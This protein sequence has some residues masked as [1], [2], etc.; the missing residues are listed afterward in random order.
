MIRLPLPCPC[1]L[2][3]RI[4]QRRMRLCIR[5]GMV[6]RLHECVRQQDR[7]N[8]EPD[9]QHRGTAVFASTVHARLLVRHYSIGLK[10]SVWSPQKRPTAL[11]MQT[12]FLHRPRN[13]TAALLSP[14]G[15]T[16][17]SRPR[18]DWL[19]CANLPLFSSRPL[20]SSTSELLLETSC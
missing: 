15:T 16:R 12:A 19:E 4:M 6:C 8:A 7:Q 9:V 11:R 20:R 17:K 2:S 3:F 14:S 18:P 13:S 1:P 10:N 5:V